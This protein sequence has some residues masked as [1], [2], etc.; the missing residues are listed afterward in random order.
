MLRPFV[1]LDCP[2]QEIIAKKSLE[3][4]RNTKWLESIDNW[5]GPIKGDELKNLL[6]A[7][8]ELY[9][10]LHSLDLQ[11]AEF[12]ILG[13]FA[14]SGIHIDEDIHPRINFP[15][16]NTVGTAVT[17]FFEIKNLE[18]ITTNDTGARFWYLQYDKKDVTLI[19]SYELT[20]PVVFNSQIPHRVLFDTPLSVKNTRLAFSMFFYNPPYHM[21]ELE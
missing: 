2:N 4:L 7:V 14:T 11:P 8:P 17:E 15:L 19:N 13:Y 1:Y 21:L 6:T 18:K 10:W 12:W 3:F 5:R 20:K 9:T 16:A